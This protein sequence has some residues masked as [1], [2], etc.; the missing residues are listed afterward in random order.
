[1]YTFQ[2]YQEQV[3]PTFAIY[4][5]T[6]DILGSIAISF[7]EFCLVKIARFR[8]SL[9]TYVIICSFWGK[10][11]RFFN[12][13]TWQHWREPIKLFVLV[14]GLC[15]F[16][17]PE[18]NTIMP[19][20]AQNLKCGWNP[21]EIRRP[22]YSSPAPVWSDAAAKIPDL[23]KSY[24][25]FFEGPVVCPCLRTALWPLSICQISAVLREEGGTRNTRQFAN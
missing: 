10:S 22:D 13:S 15:C 19:K 7:S 23:P 21:L 24:A 25:P 8:L 12:Q 20:V 9:A 4:R 14:R 11:S 3:L 2:R 17:Q 6:C 5:K 16:F 1:M 18:S